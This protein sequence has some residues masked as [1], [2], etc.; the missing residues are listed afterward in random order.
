MTIVVGLKIGLAPS[1]LGILDNRFRVSAVDLL[2]IVT[3]IVRLCN[4]SMFCC[5]LLCVHS[6]FGNHLDQE[7]RAGRFA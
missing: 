3:A 6:S 5:T 1:L 2:L 7:E 4:C